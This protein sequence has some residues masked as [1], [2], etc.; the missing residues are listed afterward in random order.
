MLF[1]SLWKES[2]QLAIETA[3]NF[4]P[5]RIVGWDIAITPNGPSIV[6]GN[7]WADPFRFDGAGD[8]LAP[9]IGQFQSTALVGGTSAAPAHGTGGWKM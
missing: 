2:C 7:A 1:R 4:L 9:V 3:R 6:E 5:L 8:V